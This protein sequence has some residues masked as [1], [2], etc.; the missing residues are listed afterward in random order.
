MHNMSLATVWSNEGR[1]IPVAHTESTRVLV[2]VVSR[3][4]LQN[5]Q[6]RK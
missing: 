3:N 6:Q 4:R 2:R 5:T 1:N